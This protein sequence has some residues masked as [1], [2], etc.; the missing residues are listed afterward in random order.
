MELV[1]TAESLAMFDE[2]LGRERGVSDA[3]CYQKMPPEEFEEFLTK[4][5]GLV[6][7]VRRLKEMSL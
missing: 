3:Q 1:R 2:G 5:H 6:R 4:V 7:G